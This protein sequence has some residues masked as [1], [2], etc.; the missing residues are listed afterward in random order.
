MELRRTINQGNLRKLLGILMQQV[1]PHREEPLLDGNVH[2][3]RYGEIIHDGS[4]KLDKL[5][6]KK[7][8]IPKLSSWEVTRQNL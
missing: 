2:S 5:I 7:A 4:G 1:A 8:Q 3:V 6:P